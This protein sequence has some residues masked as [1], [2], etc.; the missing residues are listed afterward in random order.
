MTNKIIQIDTLDKYIT[1]NFNEYWYQEDIKALSEQIFH[2]FEGMEIQENIYGA[3]RENIRFGWQNLYF[4]LNFDCCS[5]SCW[6]EG[7][8]EKSTENITWLFDVLKEAASNA[9]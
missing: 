7:Q 9:Q 2:E 8:D 6:L 1:I 5:Q 3:D 4:I